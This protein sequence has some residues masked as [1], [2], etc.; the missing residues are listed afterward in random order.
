MVKSFR[1][2]V[3][4][5]YEGKSREGLVLGSVDHNLWKSAVSANLSNNGSVNELRV[6]SGVSTSETRDAI[7]HG[8]VKGPVVTSARMFVGYFDDWRVGME[9]FA[10]ANNLV[11][12][13]TETWTYGT[14]F[15]WQSWGCWKARTLMPRMWKF[16]I[17]TMTC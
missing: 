9:T 2:E 12:P 5:L 4:A 1:Y 14:P 15:G 16:Q 6:Y 10:D 7:P 3:S 17:I 8:K 13:R 11:A